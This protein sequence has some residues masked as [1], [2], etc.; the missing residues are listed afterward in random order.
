VC[1]CAAV[2]LGESAIR[3]NCVAPG[4]IATPIMASAVDADLP[5]EEKAELPKAV[6][7]FP[8][9]RQPLQRQGTPKDLANAVLHFASDL[10][11]VVTGT[12]LPVDGEQLQDERS[13]PYGQI[14]PL[15]VPSRPEF[16]RLPAGGYRVLG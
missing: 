7:S 8:I 11:S 13:T 12:V 4:N 16:L 15:L 9:S 6:R 14:V 1:K 5:E 10:S 2:D 3:V